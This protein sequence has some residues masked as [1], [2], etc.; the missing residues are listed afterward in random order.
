MYIF[1]ILLPRAEK[2]CFCPFPSTLNRILVNRVTAEWFEKEPSPIPKQ[3][4]S[5]NCLTV[6]P[7]ES[8]TIFSFP[9]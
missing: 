5:D 9:V 8:T 2:M 4:M 7:V 1:P 3:V 6:C